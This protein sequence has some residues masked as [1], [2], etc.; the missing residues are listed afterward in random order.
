MSNSCAKNKYSA[1]NSRTNS[2]SRASLAIAPSSTTNL[3]APVGELVST[4][5]EIA[6]TAPFGSFVRAEDGSVVHAQAGSIIQACHGATIIVEGKCVIFRFGGARIDYRSEALVIDQN[7]LSKQIQKIQFVK[8]LGE[9]ADGRR[10]FGDNMVLIVMPDVH[11]K[12]GN[13]CHIL[14]FEHTIVETGNN[15]RV[16]SDNGCV[17]RSGDSCFLR[18]GN[19]SHIY[20]GVNGRVNCGDSCDVRAGENTRI[21]AGQYLNARRVGA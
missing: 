6:V 17:I 19:R 4:I 1:R 12:T 15:S 5:G 21:K 10:E 18:S 2:A 20:T 13:N 16:L 3:I 14:A 11:V 7:S 8:P 9:F